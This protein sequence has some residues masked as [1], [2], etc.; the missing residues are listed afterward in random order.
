MIHS[1]KGPFAASLTALGMV[2]VSTSAQAAVTAT[3]TI[4]EE[5]FG[6]GAVFDTIDEI[7]YPLVTY[8]DISFS[9]N[10]SGSLA[11]TM[12]T[13][14]QGI[15][16]SLI[17]LMTRYELDPEDR[18]QVLPLTL[19][20]FE[21]ADAQ[22]ATLTVPASPLLTESFTVTDMRDTDHLLRIALDTGTT[23]LLE[24]NTSYAFYMDVSDPSLGGQFAFLRTTSGAGDSG[25]IYAGGAFYQDDAIKTGGAR[26][27]GLALRGTLVPE[28][29]SAALL[30]LGGLALILRRRK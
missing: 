26:D 16:V 22:A 2:A 6:D 19:H 18:T 29:S 9:Q 30:G 25:S 24:A 27:A 21:V 28:P 23:L 14:S 3:E 7:S 10:T 1:L 4:A 5:N 17:E 15:D 12:T 20:V 8:S 13:G 11:Q